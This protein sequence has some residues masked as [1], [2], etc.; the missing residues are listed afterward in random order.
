MSINLSIY[1]EFHV[2]FVFQLTGTVHNI[3]NVE[4]TK[5]ILILTAVCLDGMNYLLRRK[6]LEN[7]YL[8]HEKCFH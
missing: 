6:I 8:L 2:F 7:Y 5:R 4:Y 3:L 1:S